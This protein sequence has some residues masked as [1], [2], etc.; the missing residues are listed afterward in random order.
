[1]VASAQHKMRAAEHQIRR[2]PWQEF[3]DNVAGRYRK[4]SVTRVEDL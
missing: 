2:W 4:I 3:Y 1:M